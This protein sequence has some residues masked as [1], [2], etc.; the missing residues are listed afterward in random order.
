MIAVA[1]EA[2]PK[3]TFATAVDWPGWSRSGKTA[4]L[5]LEALA[6]YAPRYAIVAEEAGEPLPGRPATYEVVERTRG[7]RRHRFRRPVRR[8]RRSIAARGPPRRPIDCA[9]LVEAAWTIFDRVAAG[10]ARRAPQGPARRRPRPRQ[11]GR[12]R[13]RGRRVL[14]PRDRAS[15]GKRAGSDRRAPRS[16]PCAPRCS[17]S[18]AS[19]PTARRSPSRTW[20]AP[21]RRAPDRLARARPRLGDGGP[22]RGL[23]ARPSRTRL[24]DLGRRD[25]PGRIDQPDRRGRLADHLRGSPAGVAQLA[26]RGVAVGLRELRAVGPAD[27]RVVGERRRA[28]RA[29]AGAPAGSGSASRRAGR[30]RGPPGRSP[31]AGRRRRPRTRRSSSRRDRGSAGH[32]HPRRPRR[33][34]ARRS[35]PPRSD[36]PPSATRRTGPSSSRCRQ[37]PGQP[38]PCHRRPCSSD[39][40]SNV[41]REQS[42]P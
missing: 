26:D 7:R 16:R 37:S 32:R 9:R 8:S 39:H 21:L 40:A 11:D 2:T 34:T 17:R 13:H 41:E 30:G 36:P 10:G 38:G 18:C 42:Q 29:R 14:R 24:A 25:R 1:V 28:S 22:L 3:K 33:R 31:G 6:D 20:T 27:Q 35:R 23:G 12:P 5:A 15:R 4:E 19:R